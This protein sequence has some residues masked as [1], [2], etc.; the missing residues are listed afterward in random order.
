MSSPT[1]APATP[2]DPGPVSPI[3]ELQTV[4]FIG[5]QFELKFK[6]TDQ[7]VKIYEF[8]L[9]NEGPTDW[10]ELVEFQI[11]P[12]N[13]DGNKPIDF[14]QRTAALF[15][16]QYPEMQY[17]L[18]TDKNS[19][20]AMLNFFYP[21]ATRDGFL[22]FDAFKYMRDPN[23]SQVIAFH[24]AKNIEAASSTRSTEQVLSEIKTTRKEVEAALA[25]FDPFGK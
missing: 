6:D 12:V 4:E 19:D 21:I 5:K 13:P 17:A 15:I 1:E 2:V 10:I 16:Q 14:A 20:A 11:Y 7:P 24:Y 8:Y 22:E 23:S 18:F 25:K 3:T 9:A